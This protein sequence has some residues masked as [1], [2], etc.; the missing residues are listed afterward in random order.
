MSVSRDPAW[1]AVWVSIALAVG[2]A[3]GLAP[4]AFASTINVDGNCVDTNLADAICDDA[5]TYRTIAGAAVAANANDTI[6]IATSGAHTELGVTW[7]HSYVSEDKQTTFCVYDGPRPE[8]I[9]RAAERNGLPVDRMT[10][11][12]VLDPYFYR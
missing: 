4:A 5:V 11:V 3:L 8:A 7:I 1:R 10:K 9:R 6:N 2:L 12:S